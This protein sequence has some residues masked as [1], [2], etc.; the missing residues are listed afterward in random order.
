MLARTPRDA[1][2]SHDASIGVKKPGPGQGLQQ[3]D[4]RQGNVNAFS[5]LLAEAEAAERG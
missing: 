2:G 3:A 1:F 5:R 4:R